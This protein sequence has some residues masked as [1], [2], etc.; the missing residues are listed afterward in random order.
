MVSLKA[1]QSVE[2]VLERRLG[3]LGSRNSFELGGVAFQLNLEE[4]HFSDDQEIAQAVRLAEAADVAVVVVGTTEEAESEGF[5]RTTLELPGRQNELVGRVV[6][7]N[8]RTVVVVNTGSPVLL[9]WA[10]AAPAVLLTLFPGQEYGNALA[11]VLLGRSEPSGR[12]PV[13]WPDSADDLPATTPREGIL[14]Y[15]EELSI[16]YRQFDRDDRAPRYPF[17]HGLGYSTWEYLA[18][19]LSASPDE[20]HDRVVAD[21][22]DATAAVI[23]VSVRNSGT[24]TS[25]ETLQVYASR[26]GGLVERPVRWLVAFAKA[27]AEPGAVVTTYIAVPAR[28]LAHWDTATNSWAIEPGEFRLGI[29]RSSRDLPLTV[30]VAVNPDTNV[31]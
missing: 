25:S 31:S 12:L 4:P 29:G 18:A 19:D 16:G 22:L 28:S 11:D 13:T 2:I 9:P 21:T 23:R 26:V 24:R 30:A 5:D 14:A 6:K 15:S 1:D 20:R 17:G 10:D 8:P 7:A 3:G 27:E